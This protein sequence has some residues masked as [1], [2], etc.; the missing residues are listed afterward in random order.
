MLY[1]LPVL[2]PGACSMQP[3]L[4]QSRH[5]H[6]QRRIRGPGGRFL[7]AQETAALLRAQEQE[8]GGPSASET[9]DPTVNNAH[10]GFLAVDSTNPLH[11]ATAAA[12]HHDT[13][14]THAKG[15]YKAAA[16]KLEAAVAAGAT[17]CD[18]RRGGP[19]GGR[20]K[21]SPPNPRPGSPPHDQSTNESSDP[22]KPPHTH[23]HQGLAADGSGTHAGGVA[24]GSGKGGKSAADV[25]G[26]GGRVGPSGRSPPSRK[27]SKA[28]TPGSAGSGQRSKPQRQRSDTVATTTNTPLTTTT[29]MAANRG[30]NRADTGGLDTLQDPAL[31]PLDLSHLEADTAV[32]GGYLLDPPPVTL[33]GT[34]HAAVT[35]D[36]VDEDLL[37]LMSGADIVQ[38]LLWD[39][40]GHG[41]GAGV[42]AHS[43]ASADSGA[44]AR[45]GPA[46]PAPAS[47]AKAVLDNALGSA[48]TGRASSDSGPVTDMSVDTLDRKVIVP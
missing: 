22:E 19:S 43:K 44:A 13:T 31:A 36:D 6:A 3:Y 10:D 9:N 33:V 26:G 25:A 28:N 37:L 12:P 21:R 29:G 20:G 47:G 34:L 24:G 5:D 18:G 46:A 27:N 30:T 4:H 17:G 41:V 1:D 35:G 2:C 42:G 48:A 14:N 11:Q 15:S 8:G 39:Q 23:T 45:S 7:S 16:V 38:D 32:G 40:P